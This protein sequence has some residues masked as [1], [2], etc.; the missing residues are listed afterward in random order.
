[1]LRLLLNAAEKHIYIYNLTS[2]KDASIACQ[3]SRLFV[4]EYRRTDYGSKSQEESDQSTDFFAKKMK[5][6]KGRLSL[7]S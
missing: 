6:K 2:L 1:M 7:K 3:R 4:N 5:D